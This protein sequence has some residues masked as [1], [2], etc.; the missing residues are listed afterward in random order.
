M[1]K[2]SLRLARIAISAALYAV[3]SLAV[4]PLSFG[5]VQI[6]FAEMLVLLCFFNKDYAYAMILGCFIVNLFSPLGIIDVFFGTLGTA[7]AVVAIRYAKRMY[8]A[9]IPP[10]VA[11]ILVALE[12]YIL[13]E[14]FFMSLLTVTAGEL[15]S[16]CISLAPMRIF[17]RRDAFLRLVG[18]DGRY[19][20]IT[21]DIEEKKKRRK[22]RKR[23]GDS[24]RNGDNNEMDVNDCDGVKDGYDNG[25]LKF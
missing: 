15:V 14:P 25:D 17:S 5:A 1:R 13:G 18:A 6:R 16:V 24:T 11:S 8:L 22:A 23:G 12:L 3:M 19:Y 9:I 21:A 20:K 4:Y 7:F 10:V 2:S